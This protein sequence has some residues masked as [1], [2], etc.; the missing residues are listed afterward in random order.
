MRKWKPLFQVIHFT[1]PCLDSGSLGQVFFHLV[2]L[3]NIYTEELLLSLFGM[4]ES[5]SQGTKDSLRL[6]CWIKAENKERKKNARLG[7]HILSSVETTF[8]YSYAMAVSY[9]RVCVHVYKHAFIRPSPVLFFIHLSCLY[10][11][12]PSMQCNAM[13]GERYFY[14]APTRTCLPTPSGFWCHDRQDSSFFTFLLG[15]LDGE[16]RW[17]YGIRMMHLRWIDDFFFREKMFHHV[18]CVYSYDLLHSRP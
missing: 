14:R 17:Q 12:M 13:H 10:M 15:W 4:Q 5:W 2:F 16:R 6:F 8:I 3:H 11:K 18:F 1:N 7:P 9:S